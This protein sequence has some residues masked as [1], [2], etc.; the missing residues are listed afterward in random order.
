M[1]A[2]Q[3]K[4]QIEQAQIISQ[5]KDTSL[6]MQYSC[7]K[8]RAPLFTSKDIIPHDP[9]ADHKQ[10]Q[11]NKH[12]YSG[13]GNACTSLFVDHDRVFWVKDEA[14]KQKALEAAARKKLRE[15]N[16]EGEDDEWS[17]HQHSS[18]TEAD[19]EKDLLCP[20]AKCKAKL[21]SKQWQGT[22]CSCG[23]WVTPAFK[24]L[25]AK[26]DGVPLQSLQTQFQ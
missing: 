25:T 9:N 18:K 14:D 26:I 4:A 13:K 24:V 20:N 2:E 8:C 5:A 19:D 10:F 11:K 6:Q 23:A 21:G 3:L 12:S 7:A 1:S 16:G 22:Q 15:E 17:Y